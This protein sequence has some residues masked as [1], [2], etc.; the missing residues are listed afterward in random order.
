MNVLHSKTLTG[1]IHAHLYPT[2]K[3]KTVLVAVF[4]QQVLENG[5]A[6]KTALLPAVLERGTNR[7]PTFMDLKREMEMLYGASMGSDVLKK[8]ERQVISFSLEV[9]NDRFAP[10]EQ[11]LKKALFVLKNVLADPLLAHGAFKEEYVA[12]EKDQL[13]KEIKNLINDK[14]NYA[15]ERCIQEMCARERYGV[16]KYGDLASL[17]SITSSELYDYYQEIFASHPVDIFLVGD[18]DPENAFQ[19]LEETLAFP[20][21]NHALALS[22]LDIGSS[23]EEPRHRFE[24]LPVNQGK[25]TLGYRA[26]TIYQDED[27]PAMLFYNGI[28]GG[29]PHSKLFQNVREKAS[30]AY[31][32]FSRLDKLKGIQLIGSGIEVSHYQKALDII[33]E[34]VELIRQGEIT[35]EE[36]E[37]TRRGLINQLK[38]IADS[39]FTLVNYY[40]DTLIGQRSESIADFI[41]LVECVQVEEVVAAAQKVELDTIYFLRAPDG[42]GG[43]HAS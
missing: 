8:G 1:N 32:A 30:L 43:S 39:P 6:A 22:P 10:G 3:F 2:N 42:E 41:R 35:R 7:H 15:L 5:L 37:N 20:R 27:Y 31:Y 16:Y 36:M 11:L 4:L 25:L 13:A 23:P 38:I 9:I 21:S 19:L 14:V 17:N 24:E 26:N 18:L 12:Q 34:Q 40:L 33:Q 28:L 29:F